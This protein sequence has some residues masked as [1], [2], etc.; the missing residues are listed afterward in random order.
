MVLLAHIRH[1]LNII[2]GQQKPNSKYTVKT[3]VQCVKFIQ[4]YQQERDVFL[5]SSQL[6][7]NKL[8]FYCT[9]RK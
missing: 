1:T 9:L 5:V 6:T 8:H 7:L 2:R 4:Y 3:V